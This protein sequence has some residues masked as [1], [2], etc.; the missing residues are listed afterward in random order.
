M[1]GTPGSQ[2]QKGSEIMNECRK[3]KTNEE[4]EMMERTGPTL[5]VEF[6]LSVSAWKPILKLVRS[7]SA[8]HG[9]WKLWN[10]E[11]DK[12]EEM[13]PSVKMLG[14]RNN[15]CLKLFNF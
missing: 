6:L 13:R 9:K 3:F 8:R 14:N 5:Q 12:W 2:E 11:T 4:T 15:L 7:Y 1:K 10:K